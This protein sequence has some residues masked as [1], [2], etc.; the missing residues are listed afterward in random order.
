[1]SKTTTIRIPAT[2]YV[3]A[4]D[5]LAAA[6]ADVAAERGLEGW[7]LS[8]R[9]ADEQR[10]VILLDVPARFVVEGRVDGRWTREAVEAQ[11]DAIFDNEADALAA[12]DD[13]VRACGWDRSEL[14]VRPA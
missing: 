11:G 8:P 10:D 2:Q 14:R 4:D 5:C 7:D 6:A 1:M 9:W 3:D 12:I 13:L